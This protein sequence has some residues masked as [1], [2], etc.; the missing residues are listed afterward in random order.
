[1]R[2]LNSKAVN[3]GYGRMIDFGRARVEGIRRHPLTLVLCLAVASALGVPQVS[4]QEPEQV[5]VFEGN[6]RDARTGEPLAGA[7]VSVV[8][9]DT[10]A[11]TRGDGS[12]HL[13]G[14]AAGAYILRADRLGYRGATAVVTVGTVRARRA[15][16]ESAEVVIELTPSPIALDD[17]VVTAT[18]SERAAAEALR[19]VSVM[20]GDVLQRQMTATVAGTLASMPGLAATRMGPSVAQPVI[21]GLSGD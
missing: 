3:C 18:I 21:R 12:F 4:A 5:H 14:L 10:R 19:P 15:V 7:H 11:V 16:A 9:R 17:L 6:V 13:T 1:M 20:T 2:T 8:G